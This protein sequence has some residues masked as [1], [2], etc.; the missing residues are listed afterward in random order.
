[1]IE[2]AGSKLLATKSWI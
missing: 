1:C 2:G